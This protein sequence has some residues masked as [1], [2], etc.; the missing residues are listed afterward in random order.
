MNIGRQA[1]EIHSEGTMS[2][3]FDEGLSSYFMNDVISHRKSRDV[4]INQSYV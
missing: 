1:D 2:Q 4:L 3:I